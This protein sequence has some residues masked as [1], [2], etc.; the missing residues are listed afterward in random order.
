M[1]IRSRVERLERLQRQNNP[2]EVCSGVGKFIVI[3]DQG[4]PEKPVD[5]DEPIEGCPA[6]GEKLIIRIVYD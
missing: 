6:C 1:R 3:N 5:P 4:D 2:C